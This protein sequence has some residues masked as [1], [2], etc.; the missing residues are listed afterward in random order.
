M[1]E[2][3]RSVTLVDVLNQHLHMIVPIFTLLLVPKSHRV[4]DL[5]NYAA[6]TTPF[7]NPYCLL[8]ALHS[9]RRSAYGFL[10]RFF[11]EHPVELA[12]PLLEPENRGLA[13]PMPDGVQNALRVRQILIDGVIDGPVG[14]QLGWIVGCRQFTAVTGHLPH[15][16]RQLF[17]GAQDDV[18]FDNGHSV[19][20]FID[21]ALS[22]VEAF[23][24]IRWLLRLN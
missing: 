15:P 1:L 5:V 10:L 21:H 2:E 19:D 3:S 24:D 23:S 17:R 13:L 7:G 11:E 4:S 20:N 9:H 22:V 18:A 14:P 12:D 6:H 8:A 16:R